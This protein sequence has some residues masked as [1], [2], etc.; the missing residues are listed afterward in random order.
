MLKRVKW[1]FQLQY[2]EDSSR[3]PAH[4]FSCYAL[5]FLNSVGWSFKLVFT[6]DSRGSFVVMQ[7]RRLTF[8]MFRTNR[9]WIGYEKF[10]SNLHTEETIKLYRTLNYCEDCNQ[11][12]KQLKQRLSL[13]KQLELKGSE[14]L[15][16]DNG[17]AGGNIPKD[18]DKIM[19]RNPSVAL[20]V[21]TDLSVAI[22][23]TF[24]SCIIKYSKVGTCSSNENL[25]M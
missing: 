15:V 13:I 2:F 5:I 16:K 11:N 10:C 4:I 8:T 1:T 25:S 20:E 7:F 24:Y 17:K 3:K 9:C 23:K 22:A 19:L 21:S 14:F 18:V 12:V 6:K